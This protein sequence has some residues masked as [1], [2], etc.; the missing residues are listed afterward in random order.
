MQASNKFKDFN[1]A[2]VVAWFKT[3]KGGKFAEDYKCFDDL[4]GEDLCGLSAAQVKERCPRKGD[5]LFNLFKQ[6][7]EVPPPPYV[8]PQVIPKQAEAPPKREM[9][10][11]ALAVRVGFKAPKAAPQAKP[12]KVTPTSRIL[13]M[14]YVPPLMQ[15][16]EDAEVDQVVIDTLGHF[17]TNPTVV[18]RPIHGSERFRVIKFTKWIDTDTLTKVLADKGTGTD[19]TLRVNSKF[20]SFICFK[21]YV[22]Y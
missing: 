14:V 12:Q 6:E 4:D 3:Y 8:E 13:L 7:L 22:R 5:V 20:D 16:W 11:Y 15:G 10:P 17:G 1:R 9:C 18:E 21:Q 19:K 2:Q